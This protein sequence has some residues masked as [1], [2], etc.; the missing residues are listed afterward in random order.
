MTNI[1]NMTGRTSTTTGVLKG[2]IRVSSSQQTYD[3]QLSSLLEIGVEEQNIY[4]EKMSGKNRNRPELN[5][6]LSELQEGD[7]VV[8][9]ELS[10]ISR[11]TK[12]MLQ[13]IQDIADKK[14]FIPSL[15]ETW[16]DT[17]SP[18]GTFL[19]TIFA[20]LS[21]LERE[22]INIRCKEGIEAK[23]RNNPDIVWGR[24]KKRNSRIDHALQLYDSGNYSMKEITD[25][26]GCS[27]STIY[28]RLLERK[29]LGR[30]IYQRNTK[31]NRGLDCE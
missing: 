15:S 23:K 20:G 5:R 30:Q 22:L 18:T 28:R 19:L 14:C 26:T 9:K 2:Y 10:R 17:S 16:L 1:E 7:I 29:A 24:P 11:S 21:Q 8:V 25:A 6:L 13:L 31:Y 27:R 12:D 3:R 4:K